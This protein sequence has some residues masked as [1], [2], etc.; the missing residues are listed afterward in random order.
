MSQLQEVLVDAIEKTRIKIFKR[1]LEAEKGQRH[2]ELARRVQAIGDQGAGAGEALQK[3]RLFINGYIKHEDFSQRD[4]EAL[5][6]T[7]LLS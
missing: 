3:L 2:H 5:L 4:K 7:F 1:K 6:E